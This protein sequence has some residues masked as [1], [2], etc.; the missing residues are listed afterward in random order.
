MSPMALVQLTRAAI[1]PSLSSPFR[2]EHWSAARRDS[3]NVPRIKGTHTAMKSAM[4]AAEAAFDAISAGRSND[5][6]DS[7]EN[8]LRSSW[9]AKELKGVRN[10]QPAVAHWGATIGTLYAGLD[11]W[12]NHLGIGVP[13]TLPRHK[14]DHTRLKRKDKKRADRLSETGRHPHL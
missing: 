14:A 12:L 11:L 9:V 4:L 3:V 7:Y 6:L 2:E 1:S 13:W 5:S 10:A 8:K